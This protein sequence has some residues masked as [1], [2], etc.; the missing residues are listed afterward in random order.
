MA[1]IRRK[2]PD[3]SLDDMA[4]EA[5]VSKPVVHDEFG[6]KAGLA[7]A[8][9]LHLA[10][11]AERLILDAL[12]DGGGRID[13]REGARIAVTATIDIVAEEPA[14]YGYLVR[15]LRADDRGLLDNALVR[16]MHDRAQA[17]MRL[18]AP[19]LDPDVLTVLA[20]GTFGFVF[21]A[22]ESWQ[23][24]G[25]PSRE[26]LIDA[27]ADVITNGIAAVSPRPPR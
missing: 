11:G 5:G 22:V 4:A 1:A 20:H 7:E 9:A 13:A 3:V 16:S 14:I 18:V 19:Q 12:A 2:G 17:L 25:T 15:S 24:N 8:I 26:V 10:S 6:G 27:L 21:A 23:M